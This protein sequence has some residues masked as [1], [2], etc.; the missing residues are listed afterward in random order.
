MTIAQA[1][2][3]W[4]GSEAADVAHFLH[5][6]PIE[7]YAVAETRGCVCVCGSITFELSADRTQGCA[8]RT[9]TQCRAAHLICDSDEF[10]DDAEPDPWAC[11]SCGCKA[12]NAAAG[13]ALYDPEPGEQPD[14]KWISAG[15]RCTEYGT[16]TH[17][18]G[19]K[20]AYGPSYQLLDR[21]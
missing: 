17:A 20:V 9:C 21:A 12:C 14:V 13:F 18:A 11:A 15:A 4:V 6:Q 16:L 3:R 7:G 1:G 10:W 19:W 2:G 5:D 8:Q